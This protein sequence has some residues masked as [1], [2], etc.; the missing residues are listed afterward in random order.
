MNLQFP[1]GENGCIL[2]AGA[3]IPAKALADQLMG[4]V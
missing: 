2:P 4:L 1:M 3:E